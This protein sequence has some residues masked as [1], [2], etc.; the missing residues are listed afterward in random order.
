MK[1]LDDTADHHRGLLKDSAKNGIGIYL[2][3]G[4][5]F[6]ILKP[7]PELIQPEMLAHS[8]GFLCRWTGQCDVFFSVAQH[9]VMVSKIV[10][11]E[12]ALQGLLHDASEAFIGDINRPLKAIMEELAPG[13]LRDI[14]DGIHMAVAKRF[15]SGFPHVPEVKDADN[16][17]LAT[18]KR[19]ILTVDEEWF[20]L[21]EPLEQKIKPLGPIGARNLWLARYYELTGDDE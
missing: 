10:P 2:Q 17:S 7:S 19:D 21:P 13:V 6:R 20:G 1:K 14:E 5:V 9:C 12:F 18:E 11:P 15:S 16:I 4:G 8:L 3:G